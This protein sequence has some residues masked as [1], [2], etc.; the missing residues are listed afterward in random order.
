MMFGPSAADLQRDL[1]IRL[2]V[3]VASITDS[4]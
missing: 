2:A 1:T 3:E 4:R